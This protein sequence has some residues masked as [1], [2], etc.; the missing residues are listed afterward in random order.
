MRS[1]LKEVPQT[2][3]LLRDTHLPFGLV[4]QPLARLHPQDE[5]VI[6]APTSAE[7]PVRCHRCKAYINPW[8]LFIDAG[9]KFTC[10]LCGFDN[11]G[12]RFCSVL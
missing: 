6:C 5:A 8:C 2:A 1:T 3:D 10:N 12:K 9:R 7:G 4:V 11:D